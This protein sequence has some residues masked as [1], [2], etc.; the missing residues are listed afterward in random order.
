MIATGV[1]VLVGCESSSNGDFQTA[2]S[3]ELAN[4]SFSFAEGAAFGLPNEA[5]TLTFG[6]FDSDGDGNPNTGSFSLVS[7]S[8]TATGIV[9]VGS[10][11]LS[12]GVSTFDA[13]ALPDLQAGRSILADP[14]AVDV[15]ENTLQIR[16]QDSGI[17]AISNPPTPTSGGVA[18]VLTAA[19]PTG[20]Y[21]AVDLATRNTFNDIDFGAV[22][23]DALARV[24]GGLVYVVNR[25]DGNI[26]IIDPQQG[27]TTIAQVSVGDNPQDIAFV[28]DNRAYVSRQGSDRLLI[29]D[30]TT[31]VTSGTIDLSAL[32]KPED[33]DGWPELYRMLVHDGFVYLIL[34]HLDFSTGGI[35]ARVAPGEVVVIDPATDEI[36]R[37][38]EL[39]GTD[40]FSDLQFSPALN[41]IL[42]SSIGDFFVADGRIEAIDPE[43][44]T[45]D[46]TFVVEEAAL[47][48]DITHFEVVSDTKGFAIVTEPDFSASLVSF[49]PTTGEVLHTLFGPVKVFVPHFAINSRNELY[50]AVADATILTPELVVFDTD[51]EVEL[52]RVRSGELP[53]LF[54]LFIEE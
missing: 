37:V 28:G 24:F 45:F 1:L 15:E 23:D 30:A 2:T 48:G 51:Q 47:G 29:V 49:N 35:P 31:L 3:G 46:S 16:N 32:T 13:I 8:G 26:Q 18:F 6:D 5:V 7:E 43:T 42:V 19:F 39:N 10:C 27:F 33:L 50:L 22:S 41:R 52:T 53:P 54:V 38:I 44:N 14:C 21:S 20:S 9:T 34:Q 11:N 17:E 25:T 4:R 40:P 12:V 36:V